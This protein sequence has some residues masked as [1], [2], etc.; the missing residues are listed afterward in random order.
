M[1]VEVPGRKRKG[2][3]LLSTSEKERRLKAV[4][5]RVDRSRVILGEE[6]E[7]WKALKQKLGVR[8]DASVAKVLLDSF[9]QTELEKSQQN[10][11]RLEACSSTDSC[12]SV[13]SDDDFT[14][15]PFIEEERETFA[16]PS[17]QSST[18]G[19][20]L[21]KKAAPC[22]SPT[23]SDE[24][25]TTELSENKEN[26]V[27]NEEEEEE[28]STSL[29]VGDGRYQVDLRSSSEFVVDEQ[30]ILEL[31]KSCRKCNRRCTVRKRVNG[32]KIV[33]N[34]T[35][36]FCPNHFE[37]TNLPDDDKDNDLQVNGQNT[38]APPPPS[39]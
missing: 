34:Q 35:C 17:A 6:Y 19:Q 31:F 15:S 14:M 11:Q 39:S 4:R 5:M 25:T 16:A 29:S 18:P 26:R 3:V 36:G 38:A 12:E 9:F 33:V 8:S 23:S 1:E 30:C 24:V 37:W 13:H 21:E 32:L 2:R 20:E 22:Q 10:P 27:Q 28:L 7:R